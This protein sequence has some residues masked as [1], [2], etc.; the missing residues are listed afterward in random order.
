MTLS[1]FLLAFI[2]LQA[3]KTQ[4]NDIVE[5]LIQFLFK[6]ADYKTLWKNG[7]AHL[8]SKKMQLCNFHSNTSYTQKKTERESSRLYGGKKWDVVEH[9]Q[10]KMSFTRNEFFH[11]G[12]EVEQT[13]T[14]DDGHGFSG[15]V[16]SG[17][18]DNW[19][20][21]TRGMNISC[22]TRENSLSMRTVI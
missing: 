18:I 12:K 4:T 21:F 22:K 20:H 9:P 2:C 1:C 11:L 6:K 8:N 14:S 10:Q 5:N 17:S 15:I 19:L 16:D 3:K 7:G 13:K